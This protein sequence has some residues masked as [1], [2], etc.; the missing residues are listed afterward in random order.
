[1]SIACRDSYFRNG[2]LNLLETIRASILAS[3]APFTPEELAS[4]IYLAHP[5]D[6]ELQRLGYDAW[7]RMVEL[8][9]RGSFSHPLL[10]DREV[11]ICDNLGDGRYCAIKQGSPK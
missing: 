1:M 9:V 5:N 3:D 7:Y 8:H 10:R 11:Y 2:D 6:Y 4:S